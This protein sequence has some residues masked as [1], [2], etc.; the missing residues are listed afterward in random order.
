MKTLEEMRAERKALDEQIK[1]AERQALDEKEKE[2]MNK[3]Q[4]FSEEQ[5]QFMLSLIPHTHPSCV[6]GCTVNG[7][8]YDRQKWSCNRC[9]LEEILRGEHYGEYDFE[10]SV[11]IH[12]V[13]I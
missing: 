4:S 3:I 8:M 2:V 13:T 5:I 10:F 11:D 9:M 1:A 7:Y 6:E 12:K